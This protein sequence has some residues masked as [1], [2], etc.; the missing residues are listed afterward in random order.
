MIPARDEEGSIVGAVANALAA[1]AR[2]VHVVANG[3]RDRTVA[4]AKSLGPE[5]MVHEFQDPLGP[6]VPR[7][8]GLV[9]CLADPLAAV[10]FL[11]GDMCGPI[12]GHLKRLLQPVLAGDLDLSLT[13]CGSQDTAGHS[14]A[15]LV[16]R[17]LE[18]LNRRLGLFSNLGQASPSHGPFACSTRLLSSVAIRDFAVPPLLVARAAAGGMVTGVAAFLP[19]G[20]LGSPYRGREHASLIAATIIGDCAEAISL[21]DGRPRSRVLWGVEFSGMNSARR[22]DVLDSMV[23]LPTGPPLEDGTSGCRIP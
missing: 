6:D 15:A 10:L 2:V 19:H 9:Y 18:T 3:C 4:R 7:A 20:T 14:A 13:S 17:A 16:G 23:I 1:G 11:D 22:F 8:A 12:H 21:V 5:V